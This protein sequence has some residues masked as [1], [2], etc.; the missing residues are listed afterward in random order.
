LLFSSA[1]GSPHAG[2]IGQRGGDD[3]IEFFHRIPVQRR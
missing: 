1:A 2:E 3:A